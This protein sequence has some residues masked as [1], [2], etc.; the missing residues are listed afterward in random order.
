MHFSICLFF[1]HSICASVPSGVYSLI[2]S[3]PSMIFEPDLRV[4][5]GCEMKLLPLNVPLKHNV[6][7]Q[8]TRLILWMSRQGSKILSDETLLWKK[9]SGGGERS[10]ILG[11][12]LRPFLLL[13]SLL[14]LLETS[15]HYYIVLQSFRALRHLSELV[16][17]K[18]AESN[19]LKMDAIHSLL[20][21]V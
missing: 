14:W 18:F 3:E 15:H 19:R 4:Y 8:G 5:Q 11:K 2:I 17:W 20:S 13:L 16:K 1:Q 6:Y 21:P 10:P 7:V 9:L 12:A